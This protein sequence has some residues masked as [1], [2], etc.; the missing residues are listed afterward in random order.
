[1]LTP[2]SNSH[3]KH[4]A[5][6]Y[7]VMMVL[8]VLFLLIAVIAMFVERSRYSPDF[9]NTSSARPSGVFGQTIDQMASQ[10]NRLG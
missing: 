7:T 3:R 5:N 6:V 2:A 1:M 9:G 10:M 4:H 8:S